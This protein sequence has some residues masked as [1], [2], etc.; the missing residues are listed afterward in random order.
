M[1]HHNTDLNTDP[2]KNTNKYTNT[3]P[4]NSSS[5]VHMYDP[6]IK[7]II[8][9]SYILHSAT[10]QQRAMY[11]EQITAAYCSWLLMNVWTQWHCPSNWVYKYTTNTHTD[12]NTN[13]KINIL[14]QVLNLVDLV[15]NW[16]PS[17]KLSAHCE[18]VDVHK[19]LRYLPTFWL[20]SYMRAELS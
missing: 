9:W 7:I 11:L 20:S 5:T 2:D 3:N 18:T 6:E 16:F 8:H 17:L 10:V 14:S 4:S 12:A 13:A 1:M 15:L 19:D